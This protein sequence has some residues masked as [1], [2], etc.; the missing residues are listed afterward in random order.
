MQGSKELSVAL[1]REREN[2]V[3]EEPT[4]SARK[5]LLRRNAKMSPEESEGRMKDREP[6][7]Y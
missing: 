4:G 1:P 2:E 6:V 5:E 7:K 3:L